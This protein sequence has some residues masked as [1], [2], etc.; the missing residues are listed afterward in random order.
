MPLKAKRKVILA[1]IE[2]TYG[3][4][5]VPVVG[6]DAMLVHNFQCKPVAPRY[7]ERDPAL[8]HFGNDGMIKVG[9][10]MTM[11][12]DIE[13][14]G[15]GAVATVP[16]F[17]PLLRAC[18]MSETVTPTTGPVTYAPITTAEESVS[19]YFNWEGLL[20]KM[21][22]ARGTV[23][24]TLTAGQI[25]MMRFSLEGLY[26]GV[27]DVAHAAATLTGWQRPLG[28][29]KANTTV[30]LHSYSAVLREM[31]INLGNVMQYVN[32]PNSESIR[33]IDRK[34]RGSISVELP[35]VAGKDFMSI[36]RAETTGA[37]AIVHGLNA[38]NKGLLDAGQ[39][40]LTD[41]D[42][43][44]ADGTAIIRMGM[45]LRPTASG[46]DEFTFKTQ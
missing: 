5:S 41:P 29:N 23:T 3:T 39:V 32:V 37:L 27:S 8:S 13:I 14:A 36:I 9:D 44:E 1:K 10:T 22:G 34:T 46:N 20:H 31:T 2:G 28:V 45:E 19:M 11:Q 4:D 18:G 33:F 15:A 6:T 17:G 42:Y 35:L 12:F 43:S 38:G 21:L 7:V 26:G 16:K 40:Q 30:S 24:W 25:P